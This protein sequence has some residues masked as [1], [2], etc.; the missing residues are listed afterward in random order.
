MILS[1]IIPIFNEDKTI[2]KI[3]ELVKAV[4]L[5]NGLKKEI[6]IVN[7]GS[8]DRT[9]TILKNLRDKKLK[10]LN[11]KHNLGKGAAVRTGIQNAA[12]DILVIQDADLEYDPQDFNRLIE[13][14]LKSQ[15]KVVYGT[16]LKDYP[17][18]LWGRD[19][20][21]LPSHYLG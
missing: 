10:I 12:G 19:K 9:L 13:P 4:K 20:T 6:I 16:R 17:L 1:I 8:S 2:K 18:K 21:P 11:H 7:D 5:P 15:Y 3:L 14:I